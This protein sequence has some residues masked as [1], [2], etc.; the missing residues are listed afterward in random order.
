MDKDLE[1]LLFN[2]I[3]LKIASFL[4]SVDNAS[5]KKL[6]QISGASKGNISIQIKKL[7]DAGFIK[8]KK[9]FDK[10]YPLTLISITRKG[11]KLFELF[12]KELKSYKNN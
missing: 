12:F 3:R 6:M 1:K 2:P 10:N 11:K 8:I 5:F 9:I 7:S 4:I